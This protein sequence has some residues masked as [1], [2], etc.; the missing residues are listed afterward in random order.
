MPRHGARLRSAASIALAI[1]GALLPRAAFAGDTAE[2]EGLLEESVVT[3]SSHTAETSATAPAT[4]SVITSDEI[5]RHGI[6]TLA[7]ALNFLGLG[8]YTTN[9]L[10]GGEIGGRGVLISA[11]YGNHVLLLIDGHAVNEPYGGSASF[12]RGLGVPLE[13]IDHVEVVLG[14]GAVLYGSNAMLGVVNVVTKRARDHNGV[15]LVADTELATWGKIGA[16]GG[17]T[18]SLLGRKLELTGHVEHQHQDGPAFT[19]APQAYG[20][21]SVTGAPKRFSAE[22][23]GTG[24]WGGTV[25]NA[26]YSRA[27]SAYVR[28]VSGDLAVSLRGSLYQRASPYHDALVNPYGNF[29]DPSNYELERWSFADVKYKLPISS[30]LELMT[31]AYSDLYT[32]D[33]YLSSSAAEDCDAGQLAGCRRNLRAVSKWIGAETRATFDWFGDR[34][35]LTMAG[36]DARYEHVTARSVVS[37]LEGV[38]ERLVASDI[39]VDNLRLGVYGQQMVNPTSWLALNGGARLDVAEGY[40]GALSPRATAAVAPWSGGSLKVV[41]ARAFR[42]PSSYEREYADP[43]ELRAGRLAPERITSIEGSFEQRFGPHRLMVGVFKSW[44]TDLVVLTGLNEE[45]VRAAQAE[46]PSLGDSLSQYRNS[47]GIDNHGYN[48]AFDGVVTRRLRYGLRLT[49]SYSRRRDALGTPALPVTVAPSMFGNARVSYD[50]GG[51]LPTL[52]VAAQFS[53]RRFADRA[54]DA[55]FTSIPTAAPTLE[56][57]GAVTGDVPLVAGLS[58]RLTANYALH[59]TGPYVIGPLQD[60]SSGASPTL[61]PIDR[62]RFGVGL[63]YAWAP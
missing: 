17:T 19:F 62:V 9:P 7:E 6:R 45:E 51:K 26:Y 3:T 40:P 63:Q 15:R 23:E 44:M 49:G 36:V 56:V 37:P 38:G 16:G 25:R 20:D 29:D 60:G 50:L 42:A 53:S 61:N 55:G 27:P 18:L 41:Y 32:Y 11:D 31:R 54:F 39:R 14:P 47:G 4:T 5:R 13:L 12:D 2:L 8:L 10:H 22:G 57:R 58:Y 21:D 30:R 52:G 48:A 59:S 33:W 43:F 1:A 46:D 34:D 28:V 35:I 24:V